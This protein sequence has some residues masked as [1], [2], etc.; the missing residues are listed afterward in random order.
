M[1]LGIISME[2]GACEVKVDI[3]CPVHIDLDMIWKTISLT[4]QKHGLEPELLQSRAPLYVPKDAELVQKLLRVY[5]EMMGSKEEPITIGGGTYCRD[6]ENFVSFG[7]V[8]PGE[9]ELAHEADEFIDLKEF[10]TTAKLYAQAIYEL[11][12]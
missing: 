12:K 8:F 3:R 9:P 2:D 7:P 1:N 6:V 10:V 4:C 5:N 11:I